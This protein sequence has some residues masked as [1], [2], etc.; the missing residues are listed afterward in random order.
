MVSI[1][2]LMD[3]VGVTYRVIL[4]G[5]TLLLRQ[6]LSMYIRNHRLGI[7]NRHVCVDCQLGLKDG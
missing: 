6:H 2:L 5:G 4:A 1:L 7:R 3:S